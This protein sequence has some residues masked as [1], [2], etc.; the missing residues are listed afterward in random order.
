MFVINPE[1]SLTDFVKFSMYENLK[2]LFN[3]VLMN[4]WAYLGH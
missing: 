1:Y 3:F 4:L 2:K